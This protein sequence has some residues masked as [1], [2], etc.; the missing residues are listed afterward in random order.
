GYFP[1][2][3]HVLA[4]GECLAADD[5]DEYLAAKD[6]RELT[7]LAFG[8]D[9]ISACEWRLVGASEALG[10]WNPKQGLLFRSVSS[11]LQLRAAVLRLPE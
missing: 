6:V 10:A 4:A 8:D 1:M 3:E 2:A 9:A 7:V 11:A 5:A